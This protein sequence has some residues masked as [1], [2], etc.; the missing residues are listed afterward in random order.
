MGYVPESNR[1]KDFW[2]YVYEAGFTPWDTGEPP[3][4]LVRLVEEGYLKPCRSIDIGCGTGSTVIYLASRGF[5]A[6]GLDISSVAIKKAMEK[7]R[8]MDVSCKFIVADFTD[9]ASI[10]NMGIRGFKLATDIGCFHSIGEGPERFS[11]KESL[12]HVLDV[13]GHFLLWCFEKGD[14]GWGPPGV[15]EGEVE[16]LFRD[17]YEI[18]KRDVFSVTGRP[19]F[20]YLMIRCK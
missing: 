16:A 10:V 20:F 19:M 5:E 13:G 8:V 2:D 9:T 11:Y 6:Y 4:E 1:G 3:G 15:D 18:V 12:N 7:A 17:R 14:Y